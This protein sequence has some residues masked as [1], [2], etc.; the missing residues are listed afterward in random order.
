MSK[1]RITICENST[2]AY[3]SAFSW[4]KTMLLD[5]LRCLNLDKTTVNYCIKWS[6]V[7]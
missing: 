1:D 6:A 5:D 2:C 7:H 3:K 4:N